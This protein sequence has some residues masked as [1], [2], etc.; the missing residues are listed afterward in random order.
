MLHASF[1]ALSATEPGYWPSK[2]CIAGIG[3]FVLFC[4]CL[5]DVDPMTMYEFDQYPLNMYVPVDQ[6]QTFHVEAFES[7]HFT[8]GQT[9]RCN[10]QHDHA[11]IWVAITYTFKFCRLL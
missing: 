2:F 11:P 5:L 9:D 6:T 1:T 8:Y 3:N 4:F 7:Y 10:Q